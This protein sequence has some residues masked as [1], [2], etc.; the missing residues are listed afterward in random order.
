M[1][2][3]DTADAVAASTEMIDSK[4]GK[5]LKKFLTKNIIKKELKDKVRAWG[6]ILAPTRLDRARRAASCSLGCCCFALVCGLFIGVDAVYMGADGFGASNSISWVSGRAYGVPYGVI[7]RV[8]TRVCRTRLPYG[9]WAC[10]NTERIKNV[11][12]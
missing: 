11:N 8:A 7:L 4:M 2:F 9:T 12:M 6:R 5:S 3:A 10:A 1:T